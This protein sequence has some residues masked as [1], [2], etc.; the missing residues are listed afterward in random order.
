MKPILDPINAQLYKLAKFHVPILSP[1]TINKYTL[2]ESF[3]FG[4]KIAK[5]D[6][7]YA[8]ASLDVENLL[9]NIPLE[10]K[11]ENCFLKNLKLMI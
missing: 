4:K 9:T 10:E 7:R 11:I 3:A 5:I 8:M 6:F 1:L 2:K